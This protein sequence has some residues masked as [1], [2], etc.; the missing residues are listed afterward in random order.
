MLGGVCEDDNEELNEIFND[1]L[2]GQQT[3][4]VNG[5][6]EMVETYTVRVKLLVTVMQSQTTGNKSAGECQVDG[7]LLVNM[8]LL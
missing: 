8:I 4:I 3:M 1:H 5:T 7:V 2:A 6:L